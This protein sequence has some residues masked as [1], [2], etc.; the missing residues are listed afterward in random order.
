[1]KNNC[2]RTQKRNHGFF[3]LGPILLQGSFIFVTGL[4]HVCAMSRV[5]FIRVTEPMHM[6][7]CVVSHVI[8]HCV[9]G[10]MHICHEICIIYMCDVTHA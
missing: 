2:N 6:C 4:V 9:T 1:M 5:A 8:F 7:V 10:P 3:V